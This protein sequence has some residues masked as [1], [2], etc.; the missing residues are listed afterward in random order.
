MNNIYTTKQ[1]AITL[2]VICFLV[3]S[4]KMSCVILILD[5]WKVRAAN[6][7]YLEFFCVLA[8]AS[9]THNVCACVYYEKVKLMLNAIDIKHLT[10]GPD[11]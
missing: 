8:G 2:I 7:Y 4:K 11:I 10:E 6:V 1:K 3:S 9:G 5:S